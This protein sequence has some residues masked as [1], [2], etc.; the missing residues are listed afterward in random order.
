MTASESFAWL[1]AIGGALALAACGGAGDSNAGPVGGGAGGALA[2]SAPGADAADDVAIPAD[3]PPESGSEGGVDGAVDVS[4]DVSPDIAVEAASDSGQDGA[5]SAAE[6]GSCAPVVPSADVGAWD[7]RIASAGF[8]GIT[9]G[10]SGGHSDVFLKSPTDYIRIGARLDWGGAVVFFGLSANPLSNVIDANDTGRELQLALYDPTRAMQGCAWNASCQV[11][12]TACPTSI[13]YLG[14]NPVQG[15]DECNHGAPVLSHGKVGDALEVV[16]QPLQWNPDWDKPDCSASD[17][18]PQG[19][20]VQVQYRMSFR[21]VS[22]HVVEVATEVTSQ[23]SFSHPATGQEFPTLYVAHGGSSA[24]DLPVLLDA[25]GQTV[26]LSTPGND[27][28]YYDNFT[29]PGPWVSWQNTASNY[30]VGIA[31]DQGVR[32]FQGWRGDGSTA[33]YFHNVRAQMT[34][35]LSAGGMVRGISYLALGGFGT[36]KSELESVL[37]RRPPFGT[38]DVPAAGSTTTYTPGTPIQIAG[39]ALDTAHVTQV[40]AQIDGVVVAQLPV[41]GSRPDVCTVYP[42]YEGCPSVGFSGGVPTDGLSGCPHLLRVVARDSDGN[43]SVLGERVIS[44]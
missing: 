19:T 25:A 18:A 7:M 40:D 35:G 6:G 24:P 26:S 42:M 21:F 20:P 15:G 14:W 29:S 34:F 5:D 28:F 44:P 36:V 27:G 30:G 17:C 8:G 10:T 39:W 1:S 22:E 3:A 32:A 2:D 38:L 4:Q 12:P 43:A 37:S 11:S 31:M 23:E 33:P 41:N 16:V 13:T 9:T